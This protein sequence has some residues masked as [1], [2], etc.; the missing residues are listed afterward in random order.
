MWFRF[1]NFAESLTHISVYPF[2]L[3]LNSGPMAGMYNLYPRAAFCEALQGM[4]TVGMY[5]N[6]GRQKNVAYD[7]VAIVKHQRLPNIAK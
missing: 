3:E 7:D 4:V 1:H 5:N 6:V 2:N